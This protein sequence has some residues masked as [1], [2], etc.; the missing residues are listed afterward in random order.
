VKRSPNVDWSFLPRE[1]TPGRY[2]AYLTYDTDG[3]V[4]Y[5][6]YT[7]DLRRRLARGHRYTAAWYPRMASV[8]FIP[9]NGVAEA[10]AIEKAL[11]AVYRPAANRNDVLPAQKTRQ[12]LPDDPAA[13]LLALH[14]AC[15][16]AHLRDHGAEDDALDHY[17]SELRRDG[18]TYAA[19]GSALGMTRQAIQQRMRRAIVRWQE[20]LAA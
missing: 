11:I 12:R 7:D 20:A 4:L 8:R 6:G 3:S 14:E 15:V 17:I 1:A 13:R 16:N 2:G 19:I 9:C 18:W 10:R 5:I